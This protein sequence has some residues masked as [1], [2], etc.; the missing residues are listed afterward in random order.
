MG[1]LSYRH[2]RYQ[3]AIT[4]VTPHQRI[5]SPDS[6]YTSPTPRWGCESSQR[7]HS[8]CVTHGVRWSESVGQHPGF[9]NSH[10][11]VSERLVTPKRS[12]PIYEASPM[13]HPHRQ[14]FLA[15]NPNLG[16]VSPP[17]D[18]AWCQRLC[19]PEVSSSRPAPPDY[20]IVAAHSGHVLQFLLFRW[21]ASNNEVTT[22]ER[23]WNQ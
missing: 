7:V 16:T 2:S 17:H 21:K 10:Q 23:R 19:L 3:I 9:A 13:R 18:P 15:H 5:H 22:T 11:P 14:S 8:S 20:G 1:Y 6:P 4:F 12:L